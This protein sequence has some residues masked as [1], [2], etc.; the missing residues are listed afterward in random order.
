MTKPTSEQVT[1][2]A[3]GSG[4][5]QRTALDKFRETVSVKDFGA[6]GDG[7][8]DDTAAF[9]AA[10][11]TVPSFS[12]ISFA[13]DGTPSAP[14]GPIIEIPPGLYKIS[15][16]LLFTNKAPCMLRGVGMSSLQMASPASL[17]WHGA[18]GESMIHI[19]GGNGVCVSDVKLQGRAVAGYGM[20]FTRSNVGYSRGGAYY[21]NLSIY[22]FTIAGIQFGLADY[23]NLDQTDNVVFHNTVIQSCYDGIVSVNRNNLNIDFFHLRCGASYPLAGISPRRGISLLRGGIQV[24]G[25]YTG[26]GIGIGEFSDYCIYLEDAYINVHGGYSETEKLIYANSA[27]IIGTTTTTTIVGFQHYPATTTGGVGAINW[28]QAGNTLSWYGGRIAQNIVEGPNSGGIFVTNARFFNNITWTGRTWKSA[29]VNCNIIRSGGESYQVN[30]LG[31]SASES[32]FA[33][34]DYMLSNNLQMRDNVINRYVDA[35]SVAL[36]ML[37]G[38]M[39]LYH[40]ASGGTGVFNQNYS[41]FSE[42]FRAGYSVAQGRYFGNATNVITWGTAVPTTGTWT[43]GDVRWKSDVA[44]GGSPGWMCVTNGT[45]SAASTTGDITTGT[46]ALTVAS[47]SGFAVGDY[48][49]IAGVT[50]IKRITAISGTAVTI[51]SNA[52]AT[53]TGAAVATPDPVFKAMA[54]VAA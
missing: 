41:S 25:L 48:I 12:S 27:T 16:P 15:Q 30:W 7:V 13:P 20:L 37:A 44:A 19:D 42:F 49:T 28:N 11:A 5:V 10:I 24:H 54:N 52:D 1:F 29:C 45:F 2:L 9:L 43:Q 21:S 46:T 39:R 4:A 35:E 34:A 31:K 22:G 23:V 18:A 53:V 51:D 3:S 14:T 26:G 8:A 32:C 38:E 17:V 40:A 33:D 36:R 6:V 47:A 50:G